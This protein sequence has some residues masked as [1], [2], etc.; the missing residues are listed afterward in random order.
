VA[1]IEK[2]L[3]SKQTDDDP[4][5]PLVDDSLK[6]DIERDDSKPQIVTQLEVLYESEVTLPKTDHEGN[7]SKMVVDVA[8]FE[9][10]IANDPNGALRWRLC[11]TRPALEF[12]YG[13]G[14]VSL[15]TKR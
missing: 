4:D 15:N 12:G 11:Y 5:A 2:P 9:A 1:S 10:C 7:K 13:V 8:T 3:T 6:P 14:P